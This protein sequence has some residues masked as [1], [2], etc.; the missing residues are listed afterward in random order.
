MGRLKDLTGQVFERL[1]VVERS[2][3]SEAGQTRWLCRCNC[4]NTKIVQG[5]ALTS[6]NTKSCGCY[7]NECRIERA[8]THK[9]SKVP[10]YKIWHAMMQRCY[11]EKNGSYRDYGARGITVCKEWHI[12][13]NFYRDMGDR[14]EGMSIDRIDYN[15]NYEPSNCRWA[16]SE[17]QSAN[18]R[19]N[20]LL[21]Y[22][23]VTKPSFQWQRELGLTRGAIE[24]RLQQGWSME[25][26]VSTPL[27]EDKQW[28]FKKK[29]NITPTKISL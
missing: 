6:G 18:K 3:S 8:S 14:P 4:G 24:Y 10:I 5:Y 12:F 17:T 26:I 23:G 15:G 22:N 11:Y 16:D 21:T 20:V 7:S 19:N 1:T 28:Q 2:I 29:K 13:E 9:L 27:R 25:K